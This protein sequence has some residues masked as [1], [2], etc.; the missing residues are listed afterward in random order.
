MVI[1]GGN[2]ANMESQANQLVP[3]LQDV[4][5]RPQVERILGTDI[6]TQYYIVGR[7]DAFAAAELDVT[8]PTSKL[9]NNYGRDQYVAIWD[10]AERDDITELM[11]DADA[12]TDIDETYELVRDGVRIAVEEALD[13]PIAFMPQFLAYDARRIGGEVG[14]Q[15]NICDPPNLRRA[16]VTP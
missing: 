6:G 13:V 14:G 2:I 1:P 4:G 9:K 15:T 3:M 5:L 16:T 8:F 7:G 11:L 12:T 10:G